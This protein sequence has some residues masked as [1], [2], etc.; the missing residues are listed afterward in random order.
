MTPHD[1]EDALSG[2]TTR[3]LFATAAGLAVA[4]V[5]IAVLPW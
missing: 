3:A 1:D 5:I 2:Y 4:L